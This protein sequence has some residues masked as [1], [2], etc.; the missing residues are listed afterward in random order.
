[1]KHVEARASGVGAGDVHI[2]GVLVHCRALLLMPVHRAI[3]AL[4]GAQVFQAHA[5]GKLVVVLEAD[6]GRAVLDAV[7][8]IR[9]LDGVLDVALVYQHAEPAAAMQQ[10][11]DP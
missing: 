4:A 10:E 1:M 8:A 9:A 3:D 11:I 5:D 2:A 6:S 7:D